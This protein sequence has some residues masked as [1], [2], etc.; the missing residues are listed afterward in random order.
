MMEL[1]TYA[2]PDLDTLLE[3]EATRREKSPLPGAG[4]TVVTERP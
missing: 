3:Q 1:T 4:T 2:Y